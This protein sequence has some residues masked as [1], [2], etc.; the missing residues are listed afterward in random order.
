MTT[1][2][3][4]C[5]PPFEWITERGTVRSLH[6]DGLYE[7]LGL[8]KRLPEDYATEF[9]DVLGRHIVVKPAQP[10]EYRTCRRCHGTGQTTDYVGENW[11]TEIKRKCKLCKGT[12]KTVQK[13]QEHRVYVRCTCNQLVEAGHIAQHNKGKNHL[14]TAA[15]EL[16][17]KLA[18]RRRKYLN[19]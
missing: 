10:K 1:P 14:N 9:D 11:E 4:P 17:E 6:R 16:K 18:Y 7:Y 8:P 13:R 12:G 19:K 15:E 3:Y 5:V 2:I